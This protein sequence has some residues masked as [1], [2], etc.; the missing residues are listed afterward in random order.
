[1]ATHD[2]VIA[3]ADG[4]TVRAD[5]NNVL[6]AI[7]SNNSSGS[8]PSTMYAYQF[9]FDTGDNT[10]KIRNSANNAYVDILTVNQSS[11]VVNVAFNGTI[12]LDGNYPTGAN[13][14]ALGD[15][16]L[17]SVATGGDG[18]TAIGSAAGTAISTGDNN[19]VLGHNAGAAITTG[20]SNTMI[21]A[22]A[23][24]AATT[25][26]DSTFI[27]RNAGGAVLTGNYNT[28]L[29]SHSGDAMTTAANNVAIGVNALG[30]L[31][32]T[33]GNIAVGNNTLD[34][35]V[36]GVQNCIAVGHDALTAL[37]AS[38]SGSTPN[39]AIGYNAGAGMTTG[40]NNIAI[41]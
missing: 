26:I 4:A 22:G 15:T 25:A 39:I 41:V 29:G 24:D 19:S 23:G 21:G 8:D 6:A 16:A 27:G 32:T 11:N 31:T 12:K 34:A 38:G 10:L 36:D 3:N 37:T 20:S 35:G 14:V 30:L 40:T 5:I 2:Y 13:N 18:N 17:D 28:L 7:A 33:S 1:M 9:Y